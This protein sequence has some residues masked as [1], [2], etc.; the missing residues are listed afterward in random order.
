[1]KLLVVFGIQA[2]NLGN[3]ASAYPVLKVR[4]DRAFGPL[5]RRKRVPLTAG[6]QD[7]EDAVQDAPEIQERAATRFFRLKGANKG[8]TFFQKSSEISWYA[9]ASSTE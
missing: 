6:L 3:H 8:S 4:V 2:E 9:I 7:V 5:V 1:M